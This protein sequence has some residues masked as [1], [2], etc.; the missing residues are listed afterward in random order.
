MPVRFL[1]DVGSFRQLPDPEPHPKP[2]VNQRLTK[3]L[4]FLHFWEKRSLYGQIGT[5]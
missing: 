3:D 1:S 4:Y 2:H 5:F